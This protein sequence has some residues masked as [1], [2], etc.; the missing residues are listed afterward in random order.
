MYLRLKKYWHR[1]R[2][3]AAEITESKLV[4]YI[5]VSE[6]RI[7]EARI[8]FKY[9]F[10]GKEYVS[11][12]PALKS[13]SFGPQFNYEAEL[14]SRYKVGD[15]VNAYVAPGLPELAYLELGPFNKLSAILAPIA[16]CIFLVYLVGWGWF[17]SF[18]L[19]R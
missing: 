5:D 7:F 18:A 4:D 13:F 15:I 8:S 11:N 12:T 19:V 2:V 3:V 14:A 9:S 1:F 6:E 10:R 16:A 17:M